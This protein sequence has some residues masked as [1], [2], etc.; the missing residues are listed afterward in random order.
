MLEWCFAFINMYLCLNQLI[1][2][3]KYSPKIYVPIPIQFNKFS[4]IFCK[5]S[6][7][8]LKLMLALLKFLTQKWINIISCYFV[9]LFVACS[10]N[11][12]SIEENLKWLM[13]ALI[14]PFMQRKR[15]V[16]PR[17]FHKERMAPTPSQ[18]C[19]HSTKKLLWTS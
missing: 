11:S 2:N 17:A 8:I 7:Q 9:C 10:W 6:D 14:S 12:R 15:R 16:Q 3:K 18:L 13:L 4:L 5:Q 1:T 19:W